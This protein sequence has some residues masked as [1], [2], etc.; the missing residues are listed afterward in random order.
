ID[1]MG[2]QVDDTADQ[3]TLREPYLHVDWHRLL[4]LIM[5]E[6]RDQ[7]RL[8]RTHGPHRDAAKQCLRLGAHG[9]DRA[10]SGIAKRAL[11]YRGGDE[12]ASLQCQ[13]HVSLSWRIDPVEAV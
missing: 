8:N 7:E 10:T 5:V 6:V 1:G 9:D 3:V 13:A 11:R 2:G 12:G 4:R